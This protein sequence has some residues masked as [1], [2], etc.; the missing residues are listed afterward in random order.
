MGDDDQTQ[1]FLTRLTRIEK[2][3]GE[4]KSVQDLESCN[5]M[6]DFFRKRIVKPTSSLNKLR[7]DSLV[8]YCSM[9]M[10]L[11]E[12]STCNA[13]R[14]VQEKMEKEEIKNVMVENMGLKSDKRAIM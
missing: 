8:S 5:T 1:L 11:C 14:L 7:K 2:E 12:L 4:A 9:L 3:C 6:M 13:Q 10:K